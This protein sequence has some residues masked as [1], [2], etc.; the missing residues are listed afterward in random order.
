MRNLR[1]GD[2]AQLVRLHDVG[3]D[4]DDAHGESISPALGRRN[5][6]FLQIITVAFGL[7]AL[8]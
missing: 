7:F 1:P 6:A 3:M 5:Q 2:K 4:R 8:V